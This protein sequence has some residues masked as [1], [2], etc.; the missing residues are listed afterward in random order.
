MADGLIP[1]GL[2]EEYFGEVLAENLLRGFF[3]NRPG[4]KPFRFAEITLCQAFESCP[5]ERTYRLPAS[6]SKDDGKEQDKDEVVP[7]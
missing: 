6:A 1:F 3:L 4:E 5:V 2:A 7:G